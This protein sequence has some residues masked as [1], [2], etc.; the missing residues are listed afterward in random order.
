MISD[1]RLRAL[2]LI[3]YAL[4]A[5]GGLF[6][7]ALAHSASATDTYTSFR[8][9]VVPLGAQ[10]SVT[11]LCRQDYQVKGWELKIG[12]NPA[13]LRANYVMEGTIFSNFATFFSPNVKIDNQNGT[14]TNL[15]DLII[16]HG[17]APYSGGFCTIWFTAIGAGRSSI[18]LYD[19]GVCNDTQ[20]IENTVSTGFVY[21]M[22][23]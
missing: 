8:Q 12:Y 10:F 4:A 18:S 5:V 20:Y 17:F 9:R 19:V 23:W 6:I 1:K 13:R 15:Y 3:L 7:G 21:V 14:I 2:K 16:G 11:I 22:D